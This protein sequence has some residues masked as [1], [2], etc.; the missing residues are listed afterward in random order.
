MPR[1]PEAREAT[2]DELRDKMAAILGRPV[3]PPRPPADP[4]LSSLPFARVETE[5][6]ALYERIERLAP[7]RHVGRMPVDAATAASDE[8]LALLALDPGLAGVDPKRA[9]Y[10]DTETTGLGGGAGVLAFLV[11]LLWFDADD[12]PVLEQLLLRRPGEER[13]LL[14][15]VEERLSAASAVVTYNGKSFDLPLLATRRV[16]NK[17]SPLPSRPHLDL[18]HVARR[19]HRRRL[20]ACKLTTLESEVL[21]FVRG[22]DIDGG[23]V[24]ARY[25]HYLRSGDESA[26]AAVVEHNAWDVVTMAALV[27]L[28]GEP[29][30]TLHREDLVDLARTFR[31][32]RDLDR[33]RDAAEAAVGS[34]VGPDALRVRGEIA[35]AR[36]D[37]AR[38]LAD[39]EALAADVDEPAVRLE[40][41][42]LYEHHVKEPVRAL[43]LVEQGTG[44]APEALE[45]RRARLT[46]KIAKGK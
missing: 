3:A 42:K 13:A 35:K 11:G 21:G 28:Y 7:S 36:G 12:R 6:G 18:L 1:P 33:A 41:A 4:A 25:G 44:E 8:L 15:R 20:S 45:R 5:H 30:T 22:P 39:F 17:L 23:E 43:A 19:L 9:L 46:R 29:M 32:A 27:G 14:A 10:L 37:R 24:A 31:R 26:L 2:L 38:A 34:G 16:M 40:L